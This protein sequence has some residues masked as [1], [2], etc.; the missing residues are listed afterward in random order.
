M[1]LSRV[2]NIMDHS[3]DGLTW[4]AFGDHVAISIVTNVLAAVS[5]KLGCEGRYQWP[6]PVTRSPSRGLNKHSIMNILLDISIMYPCQA[7]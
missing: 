3:C 5:V 1:A 2:Y 7:A 6:M 4:P